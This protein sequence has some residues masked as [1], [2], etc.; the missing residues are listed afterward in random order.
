MGAVASV[1]L[2]TVAKHG[3]DDENFESKYFVRDV[4]VEMTADGYN[5]YESGRLSQARDLLD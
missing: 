3:P 1:T 2:L 5:L 4:E